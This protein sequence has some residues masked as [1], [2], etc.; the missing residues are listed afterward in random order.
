MAEA[1][2]KGCVLGGRHR[3]CPCFACLK[4]SDGGG[5]GPL[6]LA[7]RQAETASERHQEQTNADRQRRITESFSKA[8]EQL[9]SDK[10]EVRLGGI[11]SLERISK[12]SPDDYW[13]VLENLTAF[14]RERSRRNAAERTSQDFKQEEV[15]EPA[16]T[17]I[18]AALTVLK[19]RSEWGRELERGNRWA[20][21]L[22]SAV[23][24]HA[25]LSEAHLEFADLTGARLERADLMLAHLEW[26]DLNYAHLEGAFLAG[27]YFEGAALNGAHL[28]GADLSDAVGLLEA[29][30]HSAYGDAETKFPEGMA[31]PAHWPHGP[32][33]IGG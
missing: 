28:E 26:A 12:E 27:A 14:I 10:L 1:A 32:G 15:G 2:A 9:G 20:L 3:D 30:L 25:G 4:R 16:A 22:R 29:Q 13:T 19:R 31:R 18:A 5:G 17:D 11:Y 23:L 6:G 8:V 7:L 24:K 33:Q 21:N